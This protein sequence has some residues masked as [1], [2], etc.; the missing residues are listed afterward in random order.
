MGKTDIPAGR[1][2]NGATIPPGWRGVTW[3]RVRIGDREYVDG[4]WVDTNKVDALLKTIGVVVIR[5][6]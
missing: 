5:R 3:G 6:L 4:K 2:V 1:H